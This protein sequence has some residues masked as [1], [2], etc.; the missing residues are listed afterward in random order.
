LPGRERDHGQKHE[1][2]DERLGGGEE[3]F[4]VTLESCYGKAGELVEV[5]EVVRWD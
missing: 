5:V 4:L 3:H 2:G 1:A